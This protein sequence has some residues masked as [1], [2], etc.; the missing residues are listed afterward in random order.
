MTTFFSGRSPLSLGVS[1][2][3]S[4]TSIPSS[5]RP[6]MVYLL[7]RKGESFCTMKNWQEPLLG[8]LPRAVETMPRLWLYFVVNSAGI[9]RGPSPVPSLVGSLSFESGSPPWIMK[10]LITRWKVVPL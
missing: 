3:L 5:T 2:I 7:S 4:T 1:E 10:P 6:K 8:S 9:F